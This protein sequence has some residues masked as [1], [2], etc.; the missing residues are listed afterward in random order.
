MFNFDNLFVFR[1][2]AKW[3][4]RKIRYMKPQLDYSVAAALGMGKLSRPLIT[5]QHSEFGIAGY[6][7]TLEKRPKTHGR[8]R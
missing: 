4:M 1:C 7:D 2:S 8:V 6:N 3:P 5:N